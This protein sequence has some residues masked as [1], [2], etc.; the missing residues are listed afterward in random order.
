MV[1]VRARGWVTVFIHTQSHHTPCRAHGAAVT[2]ESRLARPRAD[3]G[4]PRNQPETLP[5]LCGVPLHHD[6]STLADSRVL[7]SSCCSPSALGAASGAA[8]ATAHGELKFCH[9]HP[10]DGLLR[11][12][13]A[14][15]AAEGYDR[16]VPL[17]GRSARGRLIPRAAAPQQPLER[18]QIR[19]R[20]PAWAAAAH[21]DASH[22]KPLSR[23]HS[24]TCTWP[25]YAAARHASAGAWSVYALR[26]GG[27]SGRSARHT[28][29]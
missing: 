17:D 3:N 11:V 7:L 2:L 27:T 4:A 9:F 12:L 8:H 22:K 1:P 24:R 18:G 13:A 16:S 23:S 21:T 29:S 5:A 26:G 14:V 15:L 28:S 19:G 10:Q 6:H 25:P 20:S